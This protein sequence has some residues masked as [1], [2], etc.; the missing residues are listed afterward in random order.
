MVLNSENLLTNNSLGGISHLTKA[1]LFN[2]LGLMG[3]YSISLFIFLLR[4]V[5]ILF[6]FYVYG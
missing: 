3:Y 6:Y 5:S 2:N 1:F 4:Y